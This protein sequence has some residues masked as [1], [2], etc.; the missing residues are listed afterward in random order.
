MK[1]TLR[2]GVG[3]FLALMW[4]IAPRDLHAQ[5]KQQPKAKVAAI[6]VLPI[7]SDEIKLPAEFRVSLY[8]NLIDQLQAGGGFQHVYRDGDHNV[9]DAGDIVILHSTV[10][11]FKQGSERARQVTT[12]AGAT[13]IKIHCNFTDGNGK[14][15]L[16]QDIEGN[17]RFFGGN[18]RATYDFA[19]KVA[20]VARDNFSLNAH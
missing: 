16:D 15:L 12:V 14:S 9:Q 4:T 19:K 6:E 18:L 17:V 5:D 1:R 13:S 3:F 2:A 11:G 7:V 8:E 20:K 10:R